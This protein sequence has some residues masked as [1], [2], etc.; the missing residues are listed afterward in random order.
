MKK[1]DLRAERKE[2]IQQENKKSIL[3]ASEKIFA[4]KGYTLATMDDIGREAQFS[5]A[6]IYRYFRSKSDIFIKIILRSLEEVHQNLTEI[7]TKKISS[8]EKLRKTI[9]Y[10][11][12]YYNRKRNIARIFFIESSTMKKILNISQEQHLQFLHGHPAIPNEFIVMMKK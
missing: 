7:L 11:T 12:S 5:K 4:N 2:H 10:I 6:T 1:R 3:K 8:E 9:Y